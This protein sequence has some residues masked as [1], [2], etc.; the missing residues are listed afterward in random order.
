MHIKV[1]SKIKDR[2][3]NKQGSKQHNNNDNSKTRAMKLHTFRSG[4][5]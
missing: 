1:E 3:E 5:I 2:K 4:K